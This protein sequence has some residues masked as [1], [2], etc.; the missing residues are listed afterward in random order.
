[1]FLAYAIERTGS[2]ATVSA[3]AANSLF[4]FFVS[5]S[6][7]GFTRQLQRIGFYCLIAF[8]AVLGLC[9]GIEGR[10]GPFGTG[11][12]GIVAVGIFLIAAM[13]FM[14]D[15]YREI[16]RPPQNLPEDWR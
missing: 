8:W 5:R 11:A 6:E 12:G 1:M 4:W 16:M 2:L 15:F 9:F 7:F 10:G 14:L 3:V 13:L